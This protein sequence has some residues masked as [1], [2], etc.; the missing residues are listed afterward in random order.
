[1]ISTLRIPLAKKPFIGGLL[2]ALIMIWAGPGRGGPPDD[3][4]INYADCLTCHEGIEKISEHHKFACATCHL[5][6]QTREVTSLKTHKPIVRNPS[7]PGTVTQF[8][9][10][11]HEAEINSMQTALHSTMAGIINQTRTLWGAQPAASPAVYG[12]SGGLVPIPGPDPARYPDTPAL[13][14]DDFLR[15]RCL[16]CHLHTPGVRDRGLY[17]AS[18]CAACHVPYNDEGTYLGNDPAIPRTHKGYPTRHRFVTK[19]PDAQCRHCHTPNRVGADYAGLFQHDYSDTYRSPVIRRKLKPPIY[20]LDHHHLSK[21]IHAQ[22]GLWCI[23]CHD[24]QD[25]M[26]DGRLYSY[27]MAVPKRTCTDCHGGFDQN[28]PRETGN[29]IQNPEGHFVLIARKNSE[30]RIIPLFASDS[31]GHN[32]PEHAKVRC[33]ACHAQWSYQDYG[34][35]VIREDVIAD[36]KWYG[37]TAQ[38]DPYL[39]DLLQTYVLDPQTV[40]PESKDWISGRIRPGIWSVGWRFRRW[41]LMPLGVDHQ[42]RI[43]L[44]RP[45]YQYLISYVD[46]LGNVALD[47]ATPLRKDSAQKGWAFMPYIPHTIA[48]SG[49]QCRSCHQNPVAVGAGV[50]GGT[51]MDTALSIPSPPV[52]GGMGLL[53]PHVQKRLLTPSRNWYR[54]QFKATRAL[55]EALASGVDPSPASSP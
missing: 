17:R 16:R 45:L 21:D 48:P 24:Q 49:R 36:Y 41:G 37:L 32:I 42:K 3:Q 51:T 26:G 38:G 30:E 20:G 53:P 46:R 29:I 19:I 1:M 11:C 28:R 25:V 5:T 40:Y 55:F 50:Q 33:S 23:D 27:E 8:C 14:V 35:S 4:D 43:T 12:L 52:V 44:L 31:P 39:Q 47:S 2:M 15:R 54:A 13:L 18:G 9:M 6:P 10:P 7:D 22:K 34:L